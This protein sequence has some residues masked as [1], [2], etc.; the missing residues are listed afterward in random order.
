MMIVDFIHEIRIESL[1]PVAPNLACLICEEGTLILSRA[2]K[3]RLDSPINDP[4]NVS[5]NGGF[6][7]NTVFLYLFIE[8]NVK[9]KG[10]ST[11]KRR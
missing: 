11:K 8:L 7:F 3:K 2:S 4:R 10:K 9:E 5:N 6:L 1:P